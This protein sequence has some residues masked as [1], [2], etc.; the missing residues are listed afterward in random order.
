M[1]VGIIGCG[2]IAPLHLTAYKKLKNVEVVGLCD[3]NIERAKTMAARFK[4]EKT[5]SNYWDLFEKGLD[6]VDICT[7]VT[8]HAKIVSD[9]AE[10]V[11]AILLEK[12][13]GLNVAECDEMIRKV[14]KYDR[15]LCIGHSQLFSP[16]IQKAKKLV[17]SEGFNLYSFKTILRANFEMLRAYDL[18]P[19][20]NVT[21]EQKGVLQVRSAEIGAG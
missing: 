11:P 19:P 2:G 7:P 16:H 12:P 6:L 8:T 20:W 21:P 4:V 1:K 14:N 17:D 13:M 10:V 9:A 15:K 5:F 18:A 3:L